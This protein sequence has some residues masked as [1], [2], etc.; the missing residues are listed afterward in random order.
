MPAGHLADL[1]R[2]Y[3]SSLGELGAALTAAS[4]PVIFTDRAAGVV[5]VPTD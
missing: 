2:R 1:I 5:T 4:L 3:E